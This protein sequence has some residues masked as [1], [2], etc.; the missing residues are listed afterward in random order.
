[1]T[2]KAP[3]A[4]LEHVSLVQKGLHESQWVIF[5]GLS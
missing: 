1:M 5:G 3:R 4:T 2:S